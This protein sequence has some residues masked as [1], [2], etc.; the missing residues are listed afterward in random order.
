[1]ITQVAGPGLEHGHQAEFGAEV[2]V[3]AGHVQQSRGA[4]GQ[5]EGVEDLLVGADESA[6]LLRDGKGDQVVGDGQQAAALAFEPLGGIGVAALW[7]GAVIAGVIGI[8][9]LAARAPVELA[10]QC[11]GAA[12]QDGGDGP[13]VRRQQAGA[14]LPLIRRPVP[15]QNFGQWDQ[16]PEGFRT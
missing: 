12:G 16:R 8:V 7:A 14:I 10:S 3:V 6:Q 1:M 11:G 2:F 5:Q 15:A 13:P 4:L 9:L